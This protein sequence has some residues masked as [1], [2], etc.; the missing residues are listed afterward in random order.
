M[1]PAG[2]IAETLLNHVGTLGE[3]P[4]SVPGADR[5]TGFMDLSYEQI[6]ARIAAEPCACGGVGHVRVEG[7][8]VGHPA[9]G[10]AFLCACRYAQTQQQRT[11]RLFENAGIPERYRRLTFDTFARLPRLSRQQRRALDLARQFA[12]VKRFERA[13][14]LAIGNEVRPGLALYGPVGCGKTGLTV[15]VF[16]AWLEAE[17]AGLWITWHELIRAIQDTY[18]DAEADTNAHV[19]AAQTAPIL[20]LDDLGDAV[21][22]GG[23]ANPARFQTTDDR[24]DITYAV[25]DYRHKNFLPT[26]VTSN[27]APDERRVQF[28][29]RVDDRIRELCHAVRVDG[30]NLRD[31]ALS[32]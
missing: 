16:R 5:A 28:G 12:D 17:R 19:R 1:Q 9:F 25:I 15:A 31:G 27:L 13:G 30:P 22:G 26:L 20:V 8:P 10:R 21:R 7:L 14:G 11:A 3:S 23:P 4:A 29:A 32:D 18:G 6:Q 2:D 24:R